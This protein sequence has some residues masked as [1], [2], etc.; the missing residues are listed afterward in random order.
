MTNIS[1][2]IDTRHEPRAQEEVARS[3]HRRRHAGLSGGSEV[4]CRAL[5]VLHRRRASRMA[6]RRFESIDPATGKPWARD[7]RRRRGRCRSRRRE[8]RIA[9][10]LI[11][12]WADA[13]RDRSAASCSIGSAIWSRE[14]ARRAGRARDPRHRQDHPRDLARRSPM[15]PT[16]TATIAGLAD[17]I[18]GALP[19]DRQARHGGLAAPRADRRRRR[20]RAV[21][22]PALPLRGQAR[23]GAGGR[24]HGGPEGIGRRPGAAARVRAAGARGRF[25]A[26]RRQRHHRLRRRPA[27]RR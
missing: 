10:S 24:L 23:S 11:R 14:H 3:L 16:T 13:D 6:R 12:R 4:A 2:W 20:H 8:R 25:P 9:R 7:A 22:Q 26:G 21:E 19:A 18:E 27:A 5:P 17:K 1:F 15:S